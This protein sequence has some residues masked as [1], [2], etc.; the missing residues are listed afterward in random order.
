MD[1]ISKKELL[2][3]TGISYGQLYRWK[4]ER[5]IPEEWFMK[6]SS[7]TGQETFF[8]KD[9]MLQRVKAILEAKDQHSL[10]ELA[11]IFS[12]ETAEVTI[13]LDQLK[14]IEEI[15]SQLLLAILLECKQASYCFFDVVL[16]TAIAQTYQALS[17]TAQQSVSLIKKGL[18][19][20]PTQK[21]VN[22]SCTIFQANDQQN[23]VFSSGTAAFNFDSSIQII[24]TVSLQELFNKLKLK[25]QGY[26][27]N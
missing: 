27:S 5:L 13:S 25:Y 18:E 11:K 20:P 10:E 15:P 4:R 8:P 19:M 23:M 22:T 24:R 6:Q 21:N 3:I 1:L 26:F 16:I 9:Q 2:F 12:P 17:W 14:Q 7:F